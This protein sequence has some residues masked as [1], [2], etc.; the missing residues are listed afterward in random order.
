[1]RC[2]K[3]IQKLEELSPSS[4]A[5]DW[6]NVGLLVGRNDK[7]INRVFVALD[8]TDE[9]ISAAMKFGTDI[10]LTHHPLI[11]KPMASINK[12]DFVGRR[13]IKLIANDINYYAMHTNFDIMGM[14]DAAADEI[15]LRE[16]QV[17][18]VTYE[19]D[20]SKEGFG[21]FGKLPSIMTLKE[22]GEYIKR[23]FGLQ[24]VKIFGDS[25]MILE[26]AA[27]CP[28]SGGSMIDAAIKLG[29]DVLITGDIDHH[30]GIDAVARKMAIIDAGHYGIEQIYIPYMKEFL[31][32]ELPELEV[33]IMPPENPFWVM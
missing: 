21:R 2:S 24:S 28:G 6:D 13:V 20:I 29:S 22:C 23:K 27:I 12:E 32:R 9:V 19:D 14:A 16:R 30:E 31:N 26:H 4:F 25:D 5:A 7:E 3:M 33:G 1:M 10:L 15:G 11:F 17:L 8:A 18:E